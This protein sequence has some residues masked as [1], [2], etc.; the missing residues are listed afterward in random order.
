FLF[1]NYLWKRT[2]STLSNCMNLVNIATMKWQ[3][4]NKRAK[5][6]HKNV[7]HTNEP[8]PVDEYGGGRN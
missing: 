5:N 8:Y 6:E 7:W 4:E 2:I 3:N 1:L